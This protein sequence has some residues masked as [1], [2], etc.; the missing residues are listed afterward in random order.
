MVV[1]VV[2]VITP[3][4]AAAECACHVL[5]LSATSEPAQDVAN[6]PNLRFGSQT[7]Q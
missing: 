4:A 5:A 1:V 7:K 3:A 2:V 6:A